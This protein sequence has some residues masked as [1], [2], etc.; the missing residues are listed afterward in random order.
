MSF[1]S[2]LRPFLAAFGLF[3]VAAPALAAQEAQRDSAR[4]RNP[5]QEGLPLAPTRTLEFTTD[6]GSWI[7]AD[8]SP[9]GQTIVFDLLGDLYTMPI[10]GGQATPLTQGMAIDAQPRFSPDGTRVV[11]TSDRNGGE[12]VWIMSLDKSDTV[13]V[14]RGKANKY[15]SPEWTPDGQYVLFTKDLKLHMAHVEGGAGAELIRTPAGEGG[16]GGGGGGNLRYTGAAFGADARYIWYAQRQGAWQYNTALP[17]YQLGVYDRETGETSM[18]TSR[19]GSAF[20]PTLSPDGRWLVYGTRYETE[21]GL[22]IRDLQSGAERW[23]AY[24]VQRDDQES[25]ATFDAYPGMS[26]TPDSKNLIAFYGGKLWSLPVDGSAPTNVPFRVDVK[27]A[28]GPAVHFQYRVEDS[29]TFAVREIREPVPSPDGRRL[30]FVALDRVWVA[31]LTGTATAATEAGGTRNDGDQDTQQQSTPRRLSQDEVVEHSPV[32]SPDGQWIA[33]ATWS[34]ADGGHIVRARATGNPQKQTL[35]TA[36][37]LYQQLTWSPNGERIIAVRVPASSYTEETTRGASEFVW[38]PSAGGDAT[39]MAPT[40]GRSGIHFRE[41]DD[42]L[43]AHQRGTLV[44]FRWDGTDQREH[45]RVQGPGR[46]PG[47]NTPASSILLAPA[48]DRA[49]AQVNNDLYLVTVPRLGGEPPT[50]NVS[51]PDNAAFPAKRLTEIGGQFPAWSAD[52]AYV[53]WSIGNAHVVYD[54]ARAK[55]VEDS[56]AAT[57]PDRNATGDTARSGNRE[58]SSEPAYHPVETRFTITANRDIPQGEVVLRGGRAITMRGDE[59]I[60]NADIVVRNNR[61]VAIGVRGQVQVP[62]S[63]RVIDVTGKTILPGFVDTHAHLRA[64]GVHRDQN[65]SYVANLAYGVTTTR[66]PQTGTTDVLSYSDMVETG[67]VLGPRIYSTGPGVFSYENLR[68]LDHARRVLKR[69][70]DYYDTKTIKQ[71]VAGNREQRQWVIQAAKELE[72]MPTTE[73]SL[74]I[75]MNLTEAIDGYSGHEHSWPAFPLQPD[76]IKVFAFSEIV[77]TPTILVA[78]GGPWAENHY[79]ATENVIHNEKL[80]RF[81]PHDE[82]M[83][84]ARRRNAGWFH[85]EE[86]VFK[87]IGE[88]VADLVAAGG[89]A[90]V[91]SHGQLQGLG[92]HW[93]LWS[94]AS[95]GLANHDALRVATI[96]GADAIGFGQDLGSIETGKLAD[97]VILDANPLEDLRNT[98]TVRMVMK[99]GRLYDGDTLDE[100]WPRQRKASFYWQLPAPNPAAGIR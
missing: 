17:D 68:D 2:N 97:L 64:R 9:D 43:Y 24:P 12:G 85:E 67:D 93:E 34:D 92:W 52:G 73:G 13:Q 29:P 60:E 100:V 70:S 81:T 8:V 37:A 56:V 53:H 61:I 63:A 86:H 96:M 59:V 39:F 82:V 31:D 35:T 4:N 21:T 47:S 25:R 50:I 27:L 11:F 79:Y 44:S 18:R 71:Y 32:W 33:Y 98:N 20:R 84:K 38:I 78:Y 45:V 22:R 69:Y 3:A 28:M 88:T 55:V 87:K 90:G 95:G 16:R 72:L 7:S 94:V 83:A 91:G 15:D 51:N 77:Y 58:R 42:R 14:T 54:L 1:R 10:G 62:S 19:I 66:D 89:K 48:G 5:V 99:N 6:V 40:D 75:E 23:L 36:A 57:R 30:A 65:W 80:L 74:D 76:L 41:G 46:G 49:I 26:F